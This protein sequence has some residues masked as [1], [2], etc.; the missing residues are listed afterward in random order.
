MRHQIQ[1]LQQLQRLQQQL[2]AINSLMVFRPSVRPDASMDLQGGITTNEVSSENET[3][4]VRSS[5]LLSLD[6]LRI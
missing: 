3:A 5:K 2:E 4:P 6:D 1:Q